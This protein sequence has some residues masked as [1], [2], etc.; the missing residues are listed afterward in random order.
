MKQFFF[1]ITILLL[2]SSCE[3][4]KQS[5]QTHSDSTATK[6]ENSGSTARTSSNADS[7]FEFFKRTWY[8]PTKPEAGQNGRDGKDGKDGQVITYPVYY[9][10]YTEEYGKGQTSKQTES[11]DSIWKMRYDSLSQHQSSSSTQKEKEFVTWQHLVIGIVALAIFAVVFWQL[12]RL[13]RKFR[14]VKV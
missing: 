10:V 14:I 5:T 4:F 13:I 11:A 6:K 1:A 2:L 3:V 7:A 9:P 12:L 8:Q